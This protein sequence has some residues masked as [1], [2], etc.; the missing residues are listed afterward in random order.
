MRAVVQRV[1]SA[2]VSVDEQEIARIDGGLLVYAGVAAEDSSEDSL[3]LAK[4]I[5]GLRIFND[6]QGKFNL[7]VRQTG[8]KVMLVSN[9]TLHGDGRKGR[10]PSFVGT[11]GQEQARGLLSELAKQIRGQ[12]IFVAE[13]QFAAHMQIES[14]NDGPV[15][16]LLDSSKV[17]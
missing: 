7:D 10:R 1:K 9:F 13:G 17:F 11:A 12:G 6:E 3:Y 15:N 4:K 16:V 8:G 5:V 2:R 14:V